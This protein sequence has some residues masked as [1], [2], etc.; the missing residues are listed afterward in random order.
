M[1]SLKTINYNRQK[2]DKKVWHFL[3]LCLHRWFRHKISEINRI[4]IFAENCQKFF[5]VWGFLLWF[6]RVTG[7]DN[8]ILSRLIMAYV[9]TPW[10]PWFFRLLFCSMGKLIY[11]RSYC[12]HT[13]LI[14]MSAGRR[15]VEN[16]KMSNYLRIGNYSS[17]KCSFFLYEKSFFALVNFTCKT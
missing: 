2:S 8:I 13:Y 17:Q 15:N 14:F 11:R 3:L 9:G 5:W 7:N 16:R 4:I 10:P 1:V 6:G 12:T